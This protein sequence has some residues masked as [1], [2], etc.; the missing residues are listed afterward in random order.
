M[1]Q[2]NVNKRSIALQSFSGVLYEVKMSKNVYN[3]PALV[4]GALKN[5][6]TNV[7]RMVKR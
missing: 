2:H 6:I 4:R 7:K 5:T 1:A 3:V